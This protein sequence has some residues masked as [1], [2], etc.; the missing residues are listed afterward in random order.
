MEALRVRSEYLEYG[1]PPADHVQ[2]HYMSLIRFATHLLARH[3]KTNNALEQSKRQVTAR[4]TAREDH[5][6]ETQMLKKGIADLERSEQELKPWK[7]REPKIKHYLGVFT[8]V[9]RYKN[10]GFALQSV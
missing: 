10:M 7:E 1:R 8:E 6:I 5:E 4:D 2:F 3:R 9:T